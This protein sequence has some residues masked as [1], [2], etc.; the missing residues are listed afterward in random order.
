[1]KNQSRLHKKNDPKKTSKQQLIS[2]DNSASKLQLNPDIE[3]H[4]NYHG[5]ISPWT[6]AHFERFKLFFNT[7]I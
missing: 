1:M 4:C 2:R 3:T 7:I 6:S 5:Q